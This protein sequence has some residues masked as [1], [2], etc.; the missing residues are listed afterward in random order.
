MCLYVGIKNLVEYLIE[1][2]NRAQY[3]EFKSIL[4][5]MLRINKSFNI[6]IFEFYKKFNYKKFSIL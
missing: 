1:N 5:S 2:Q 4:E 6:S 3:K